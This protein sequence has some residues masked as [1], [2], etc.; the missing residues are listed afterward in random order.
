MN[1][2]KAQK[3]LNKIQRDLMRNGIITNT[4]VNDLKELRPLVVE[5]GQPLLAKVIR[6]TY[7]HVE[8][9]DS[10]NIAIP[11]DDPVEEGEEA[12]V[13]E[14]TTGQESLDYLLSLMADPSNRVN[15]IELREYVNAFNEYAEEN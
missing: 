6:L 8:A 5:E 7:E 9:Y 2:I 3:L 13:Q 15:E 12:P 11:G 10:F 4:L 1:N 14:E